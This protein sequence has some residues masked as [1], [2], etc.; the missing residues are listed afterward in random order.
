MEQDSEY[1]NNPLHIWSN[2]FF[3]K[4]AK[5]NQWGKNSLFNKWCQENWVCT[6]NTMKLDPYLILYI[7]INSKQ[8]K[9]DAKTGNLEQMQS[10]F[11]VNEVERIIKDD[12]KRLHTLTAKAGTVALLDTSVIHRGLPMR[13]GVRYALTNYFFEKTQMN[14]HLVEHFSPIVSPEK[15]LKMGQK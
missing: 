2:D 8:I 12:P 6:Y 9:E 1:R 3:N 13:K 14:S 4:G 7:R 11:D 15:V 5:P 10:R